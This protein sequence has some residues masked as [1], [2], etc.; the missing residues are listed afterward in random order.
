MRST[1]TSTIQRF[2]PLFS[3]QSNYFGLNQK[4]K[5]QRDRKK[6]ENFMYDENN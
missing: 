4:L 1:K 5:S 6:K 2:P 3:P